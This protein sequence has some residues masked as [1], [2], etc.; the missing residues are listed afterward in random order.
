M[1]KRSCRETI[2]FKHPL[3]LQGIDRQLAAG[4]YE[5][6]TNK[7]MIEGLPSRAFGGSRP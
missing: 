1:T 3:R 5:V 2:H 4:A 7:E 6:I